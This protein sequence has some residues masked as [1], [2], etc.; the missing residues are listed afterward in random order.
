MAGTATTDEELNPLTGENDTKQMVS[1]DLENHRDPPNPSAPAVSDPAQ[2]KDWAA[3]VGVACNKGYNWFPLGVFAWISGFLL[4]ACC[5]GD[6]ITME[7]NFIEFWLYVYVIIGALLILLIDMPIGV[8]IKIKWIM[9]CQLI[10]FDWVKLF[11]RI[12][13]RC[14]LY[15]ILMVTCASFLA[16]DNDPSDFRSVPWIGGLYLCVITVLSFI[17]SSVAAKKYNAIREYIIKST[18][19]QVNDDNLAN[20]KS[21]GML[22]GSD[23]DDEIAL[24]KFVSKYNELDTDNT[25]KLNMK[26]LAQLGK[27]CGNTFSN[28]EKH[29]IMLLLDKECNGYITRPEW[30]LQLRKHKHLRML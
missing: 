3:E 6:M 2:E 20:L 27:E 18:V 22:D 12:W 1:V 7:T 9:K 30:I 21:T 24:K 17:F 11:R 8:S 29:A 19:I 15:I 26:E 23:V 14:V 25:G 10:V 16:N 13:G 28:S 4:I 5:L